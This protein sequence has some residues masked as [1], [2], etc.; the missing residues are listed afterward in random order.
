MGGTSIDAL[1]ILQPG[2][3]GVARDSSPWSPGAPNRE[4]AQLVP[5]KLG[6]SQCAKVEGVRGSLRGAGVM[7]L[8][9]CVFL[10]KPSS[11]VRTTRSIQKRK[12]KIKVQNVLEISISLLMSKSQCE[13]VPELI[14]L[15][16]L[17]RLKEP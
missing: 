6:F 9:I 15:A 12:K 10:S 7:I 17:A 14:I 3:L 11:Q 8:A 16:K 4:A 5:M 2:K 13:M 1:W